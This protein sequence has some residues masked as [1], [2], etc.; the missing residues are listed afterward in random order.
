MTLSCRRSAGNLQRH[1]YV[2]RRRN[3]FP[4]CPTTTCP[5]AKRTAFPP[6]PPAMRG[7]AP[8]SAASPPASRRRGVFGG[9]DRDRRRGRSRGGARRPEGADHEGR[10]AD[11]DHPGSAAARIRRRTHQAAERRPADGLA[12]RQAPHDGRARASTGR[13]SSPTSSTSRRRP[14]RSARCIAPAPTT[15]ARSP[16][17]CSIRTCSRRSR[18]TCSSSSGC[19]PSTA[20]WTRRSTP[21]E[22]AKEI[23]ARVREE[24]DYEREAKHVALYGAHARRR[25]GGA[26]AAGRGRS[27]RP[28]G[29][30]PSTGSTATRLLAHKEDALEVRNRIAR[31]H[32]QGVVASVQPLRRHPRRS[33]SRQLHR[34]FGRRRAVRHQPARL[35]LRAHLPADIRRRRRRSLPG[36]AARPTTTASSTPTRPGAS[37]G[38]PAR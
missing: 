7:S 18:P 38:S 21:R 29:C 36:P 6:A 10:P 31:R 22:I 17:S 4:A 23:G 28:G 16:A 11:G 12:V 27:C 30:S 35:R 20:A 33:A 24:L 14:P 2:I 15:A 1:A 34:V 26:R 8:M 32:V 37:S 9:D 25:A 3:P 5:T 13:R 19:S